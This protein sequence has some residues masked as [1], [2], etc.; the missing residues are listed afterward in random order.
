MLFII[1]HRLISL[2]SRG[3]FI[4]VTFGVL[5]YSQSVGQINKHLF[6]LAANSSIN[7]PLKLIIVLS[8]LPIKINFL[9]IVFPLK[10]LR[11]YDNNAL[12]MEYS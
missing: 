1:I 5:L 12:L 10:L 3:A 4:T 7:S 11:N 2:P 9:L 6:P 8:E